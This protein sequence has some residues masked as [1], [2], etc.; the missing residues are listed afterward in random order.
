MGIKSLNFLFLFIL[1]SPCCFAAST[2]FIEAQSATGDCT[3]SNL[4]ATNDSLTAT[5]ANG[6]ELNLSDFELNIYVPRKAEIVGIEVEIDFSVGVTTQFTADCQLLNASGTPVGDVK[7]ATHSSV[8]ASEYI[9]GGSSDLW[10]TSLDY[11]NLIDSNFG[12]NCTMNRDSGIM[13][14]YVDAIRVKIYFNKPR[15]IMKM[16]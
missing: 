15:R 6:D 16:S 7:S 1:I 10:G 3:L 5:C 8:M 13:S 9:L 14:S 12:V 2:N 4:V 11:V